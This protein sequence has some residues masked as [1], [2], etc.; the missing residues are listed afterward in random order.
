M[1]VFDDGGVS[2]EQRLEAH[3]GD[4]GGG[5]GGGK[6]KQE[7]V[8]PHPDPSAYPFWPLEDLMEEPYANVVTWRGRDEAG[9]PLL[10]VKMGEAVDTLT[11]AQKK[12]MEPV[13]VSQCYHGIGHL[14]LAH[15]PSTPQGQIGVLVDCKGLSPF[16]LP[17]LDVISNGIVALG[18]FFGHRAGRYYLI[19]TP[20]GADMFIRLLATVM[21]REQRQKLRLVNGKERD[22]ILR[23]QQM[24]ELDWPPSVALS[25]PTMAT[26]TTTPTPT[27]HIIP[28]ALPQL[29]Q[30]R[31]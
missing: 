13:M 28:A 16:K 21:G 4:S 31:R 6:R 17:P 22:S 23:M 25:T 27:T 20:R 26:R 18:R 29:P 24:T 8:I 12:K 10:H 7:D 9:R 2:V 3:F 30:R 1:Y 15:H 11:K 5:G 14:C 19:N